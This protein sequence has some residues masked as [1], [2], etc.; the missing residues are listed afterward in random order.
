M[1][2]DYLEEGA[3][4]FTTV[5]G[6]AVNKATLGACL[7]CGARASAASRRWGPNQSAPG[8]RIA[9]ALGRSPAGRNYYCLGVVLCLAAIPSPAQTPPP[10]NFAQVI[11]TDAASVTVDFTLRPIRH[12]NFGVLV[13]QADGSFTNHLAD[14][15]R[16]YLGT[17]RG[18]PGAVAAG[19]LRAGGA[20]WAQI[21]F[22]NGTT[23]TTKGGV[24]KGSGTGPTPQW[25]TT[26]IGE[27]GAGTNVHAVEVG[28]DATY[29]HFLA[30]GSTPAGVLDSV[31]FSLMAA[32]LAYLRDAGIE[33]QLGKLLVRAHQAQDP[34]VPDGSDKSL[35]LQRVRATW[36]T[37]SP[38]GATH[39]Q[40]SVI[41]SGL[42]G[43]LAYG[44][45]YGVIGTSLAYATVD[46]DSGDFWWV[47]RHG[48]GSQLGLQPYRRRRP[49]G[50]R[51]H[52]D[53]R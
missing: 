22:E 13:Q 27:G 5:A 25:P 19:L 41:H 2:R 12:A 49:A 43:G 30:C 7:G 44:G 11:S 1:V 20:L 37:G 33:N 9:G 47:W 24:A 3:R 46:S 45:L 40:A 32:N 51:H 4:W 8:G 38:M 26:V 34:Y 21:S 18:R 50:G 14:V 39:Q 35:L 42:N 15:P 52:Y 28:I 6:M 53:R 16:T 48:G 23:W 17:V 29:S 10:A 36:T 31:E